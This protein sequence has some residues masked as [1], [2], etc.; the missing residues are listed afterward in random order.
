MLILV[1]ADASDCEG[2]CRQGVRGW[3][4]LCGLSGL[5]FGRLFED[6]QDGDTIGL[7]LGG[8]VEDVVDKEFDGGALLKGGLPDMHQFRR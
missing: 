7:G 8:K 4:R 3:G 5:A 1:D 6:A 2:C